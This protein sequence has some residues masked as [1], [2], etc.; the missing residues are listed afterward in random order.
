MS[1]RHRTSVNLPPPLRIVPALEAGSLAE[2]EPVARAIFGDG[3]RPRG[4][5]ERK[6]KRECVDPRLSMVAVRGDHGS[7]S[8]RCVGY[9]LVGTPP[10]L[11]PIV[12]TAGIGVVPALRRRSLGARLIRAAVEEVRKHDYRAIR[13]P[14]DVARLGFYLEQEFEPLRSDVSLLSFGR[15]SLINGSSDIEPWGRDCPWSRRRERP[16]SQWLEEAWALTP[17]SD[18]TD[19]ELTAHRTTLRALISKEGIARVLH[20]VLVTGPG[21]DATVVR[22]FDAL[23]DKIADGAPIVVV[24]VPER[25][26]LTQHLLDA[27]WTVAQRVRVMERHLEVP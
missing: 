14:A 26:R 23:K 21:D 15:G 17:A 4:W 10:S 3:N 1:T 12:R 9:A 6:L 22:L 8:T 20:R 7:L 27:G 19:I 11:H 24:G 18:R 5:F 16:V 2:L 13:I 25:G